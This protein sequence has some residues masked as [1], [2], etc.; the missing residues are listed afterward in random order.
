MSIINIINESS[1]QDELYEIL[2]TKYSLLTT[3]DDNKNHLNF[4]LII[5]KTIPILLKNKENLRKILIVLMNIE[6]NIPKPVYLRKS[7]TSYIKTNYTSVNDNYLN[8]IHSSLKSLKIKIDLSLFIT[9][10][11]RPEIISKLNKQKINFISNTALINL[12]QKLI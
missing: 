9:N 1:N 8:I 6:E 12:I 5:I 10:N 4:L 3:N 2:I 11:E 7:I